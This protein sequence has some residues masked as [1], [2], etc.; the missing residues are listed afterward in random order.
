MLS[1]S[2]ATRRLCLLSSA[3]PLGLQRSR[4]HRGAKCILSPFAC[5]HQPGC[6]SSTIGALL[7]CRCTWPCTRNCSGPR[8]SCCTRRI[9]LRGDARSAAFCQPQTR[10]ILPIL[11]RPSCQTSG[12]RR[13][14]RVLGGLVW[15][16]RLRRTNPRTPPSDSSYRLSRGC[17]GAHVS[18]S[19]CVH[20]IPLHISTLQVA[21][22]S[23]I[24]AI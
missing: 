1:L 11:Q 3:Y 20:S 18:F 13:F 17:S 19:C 12:Q 24:T 9:R 15:A 6:L 23:Q 8:L 7:C 10:S 14:M 21:F 4:N 2:S 5:S 16:G 22:V